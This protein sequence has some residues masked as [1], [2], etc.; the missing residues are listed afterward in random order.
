MY[1]SFHTNSHYDLCKQYICG[2]FAC[3]HGGKYG[4]FVV[5]GIICHSY[6]C[7]YHASDIG[8]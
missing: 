2:Y 4:L 1:T 8:L 7:D 6:N 3:P 5:E